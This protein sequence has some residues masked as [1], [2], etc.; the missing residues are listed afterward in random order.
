MLI[1]LI[2]AGQLACLVLGISWFLTRLEYGLAVGLPEIADAGPREML[3][4]ILNSAYVAG[5]AIALVII[6]IGTLLTIFI[7]QRYE[8][9]LSNSNDK[10]TEELRRRG[11]A[12]H[13]A[14]DAVVFGLAKLAESRDDDT[15][16]HL[17]R[18]QIYVG[19]LAQELSHRYPTLT[20]EQAATL[21]ATSALHDIGKVGIPD[22][23][24]LKPARLTPDEREIIQTHPEIG[25][26]CLQAIKARL[27]DD[28]FFDVACEIAYSH[29]ERWDGGGYPA[30]LKG[31]RIPLSA[32]IVALAD[33]YDALTTQ[34]VYKP[35]YSHERARDII[36]ADRGKH[37]D[38]DVVD[39]FIAHE[40]EFERITLA[41]SA[42]RRSH[43]DPATT[44]TF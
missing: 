10:L 36:V 23:V 34:R 43:V 33:T 30:G 40:Q 12:L 2:A 42:A 44:S 27:E 11:H 20:Q 41:R 22:A 4:R 3:D 24:L 19:I 8:D 7:L 13:R 17:D 15:G 21:K 37:F 26:R 29:H 16:E 1:L 31:D 18:I 6:V 35:A 38:P 25:G 39:A 9:R 28:G 5:F 32:R 14:R